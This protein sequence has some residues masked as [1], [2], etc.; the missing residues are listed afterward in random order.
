[1]K[2]EKSCGAIVYRKI[3]DD[4]EFLAIK[5]N[6]PG[7]HWGFPKGHV[8]E[9]ETE[10]ETCIREVYEETGLV[11]T[12]QDGFIAYD[13]Y[14]ISEDTYKEVVFFLA[15]ATDQEV[16]VNED[17]VKEYKWA[18]FDEIYD[19]VTYDSTRNILIKAREYIMNNEKDL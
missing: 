12:P 11:V 17:E 2:L 14:K 19:L 8:E 7:E 6:S 3:N 18:S 4:I 9:G 15:F 10:K 5:S 16:V 13:K 1:M